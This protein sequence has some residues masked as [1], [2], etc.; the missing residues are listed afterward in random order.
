VQEFGR[1]K[2]LPHVSLLFQADEPMK[3]SPLFLRRIRRNFAPL[4]CGTVLLFIASLINTALLADK[5]GPWREVEDGLLIGELAPRQ[6]S[7]LG[8]ARVLVI[9]VDPQKYSFKLMSASE[10]GGR[11]LTAKEWCEKYQLVAAFNAGMYQEDGVT[12]VGYMKNFKHINNGRLNRNNAVLAFNPVGPGVPEIQIID[13]ECQDFEKLKGKYHSLVQSIR[14]VSCEQQNVW[15]PQPTA[16]S[17]LAIGMDKS[18]QVLLI[19]SRQPYCV[20]DLIEILL[21]L[22]ISIYNAMYLEGGPQA[23]LYLSTK[24]VTIEKSGSLEGSSDSYNPIQVSWPIPNVIGIV[25]K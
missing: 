23:S 9:K 21:T 18:G 20:H 17:T 22:P 15:D 16:W 6:T 1:L 19:F 25:K 4:L 10:Y 13:R 3:L 11:K 12:S 7:G 5:T 24:N 8:D 2:N 14:M